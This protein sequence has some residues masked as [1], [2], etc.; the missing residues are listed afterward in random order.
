MNNTKAHTV[1]Y[2]ARKAL[3]PHMRRRGAVG[4][5]KNTSCSQVHE[6]ICGESESFC[7]RWP[8]TQRVKRFVREHKRACG[9]DLVHEAL[10]A[11]FNR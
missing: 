6:C 2:N 11:G 7:P 8:M 4:I 9:L 3:Y 5:I 10:V 1:I